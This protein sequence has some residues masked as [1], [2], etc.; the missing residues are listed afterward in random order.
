MMH[1]DLVDELVLLLGVKVLLHVV[2]GARAVRHCVVVLDRARETRR[3]RGRVKGARGAADNFRAPVTVVVCL[4]KPLLAG[5][6][7]LFLRC[8]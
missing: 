7:T 5:L 1:A 2:L 4:V 6:Y 3:T 8:V